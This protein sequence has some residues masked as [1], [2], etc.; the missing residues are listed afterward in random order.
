MKN[1]KANHEKR[2]NKKKKNQTKV[3]NQDMLERLF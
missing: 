3:A 2:E 1:E